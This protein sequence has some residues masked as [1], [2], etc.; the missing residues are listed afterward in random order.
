MTKSSL[1]ASCLY[2]ST[3]IL[4]YVVQSININKKCCCNKYSENV[5]F[6]IL[7]KLSCFIFIPNR[8]LYKFN[9]S[10]FGTITVVSWSKACFI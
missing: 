5:P 7:N 6:Q 10:I 9:L 8:N 1:N 2:I 4:C 3:F